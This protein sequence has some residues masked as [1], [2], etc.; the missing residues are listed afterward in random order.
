LNWFS[1]PSFWSPG[2]PLN[3]LRRWGCLPLKG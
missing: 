2:T 3:V 1:K